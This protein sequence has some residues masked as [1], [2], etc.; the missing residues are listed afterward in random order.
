MLV[1]LEWDYEILA[2]LHILYTYIEVQVHVYN[3]SESVHTYT[4]VDIVL[5]MLSVY[6]YI[7]HTC[8]NGICIHTY[9]C[10]CMYVCMLSQG[11]GKVFVRAGSQRPLELE[12]Y[13]IPRVA[14]KLSSQREGPAGSTDLAKTV[15]TRANI[16]MYI[17][18]HINKQLIQ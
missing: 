7:A 15:G 3:I 13:R 14:Y 5:Y 4:Y 2:P 12:V 1:G 9:I 6:S 16:C 10:V 8:L 11:T 18:I 17:Y